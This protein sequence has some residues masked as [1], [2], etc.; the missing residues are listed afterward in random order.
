MHPFIYNIT[1]HPNMTFKNTTITQP[2]HD[3][4][5]NE[6]YDI[7][8]ICS[9]IFFAVG[10]PPNIAIIYIISTVRKLGSPINRVVVSLAFSDCL[11]LAWYTITLLDQIYDFIPYP[12]NMERYFL[13]SIDMFMASASIVNVAALS[14]DRLVGC[15]YP[16]RYESLMV[17]K[18][19]RI[20][21]FAWSYSIIICFAS[22][23]RMLI[24]SQVYRMIVFCISVALSFGLPVLTVVIT[25]IIILVCAHK[26]IKRT[27][28]LHRS[29]NSSQKESSFDSNSN[30]TDYNQT[31]AQRRKNQSFYREFKVTMIILLIVFPF[32]LGWTYYVGAQIYE[33]VSGRQFTG[34]FM[35]ITFHL[36][37]SLVSALNPYIYFVL[38]KSFR[39][40]IKRKFRNLFLEHPNLSNQCCNCS[41]LIGRKKRARSSLIQMQVTGTTR[42]SITTSTCGLPAPKSL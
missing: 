11:Y 24:E 22:F 29:V 17:T 8:Y 9:L 19:P 4:Q 12:Q 25:Y 39:S 37:P 36:T 21:V 1:N 5:L 33:W 26:S 31:N 23:F 28:E 40:A 15:L 34:F 42:S 14:V 32:T 6:I 18:A 13:P 30:F 10:I 27:K 38:S 7:I 35:N 16:L 20:I 41:F 2:H 3:Y